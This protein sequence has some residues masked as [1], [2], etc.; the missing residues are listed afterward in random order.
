MKKRIWI[1]MLALALFA[2]G[3]A[4]EGGNPAVENSGAV[5]TI[6][7]SYDMGEADAY[8]T[9]VKAQSAALKKSLAEDALTQFDMNMKSKELY[10][11]WDGALNYLW[12]E[13]KNCMPEDEFAKLTEEQ[14]QWIADKE[15]SVEEVGRE[16]EGGSIYALIVNDEAAA[17][18]EERVYELYELLSRRG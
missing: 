15:K 17:I 12:G 18:T 11:L 4:K 9:S 6:V 1:L 7:P 2:A 16:F 5:Q 10:D 8:M 14:L 3:C 13:L